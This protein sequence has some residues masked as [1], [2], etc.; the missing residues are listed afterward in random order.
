M[1]CYCLEG[2]VGHVRQLGS[3]D[4]NKPMW[5]YGLFLFDTVVTHTTCCMVYIVFCL[6]CWF[7][8]ELLLSR[9]ASFCVCV[10][11]ECPC[12]LAVYTDWFR[13]VLSFSQFGAF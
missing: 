1:F 5:D 10:V 3:G 13:F 9:I 12:F 4:K 7:H 8:M 6:Y 11:R 2:F